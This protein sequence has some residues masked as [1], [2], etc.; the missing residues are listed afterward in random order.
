MIRATT[1]GVLK[2][3][4]MNLNKSYTQ[5]NDAR[6]TVLTQRYFNSYAEDPGAASQAF[7]LRR[8]FVRTNS[9]INTCENATRKFQAAWSAMGSVVD[10]VDNVS[11]V[12]AKAA[13]LMG[14][15]DPT[16]GGRAAL[17]V[18]LVELS[19]SIVQALNVRYGDTFVFA[20]ADGMNVPFTWEDRADGTGKEL[21]YRGIPVDTEVPQV[22]QDSDKTP[23]AYTDANG[24][25]FYVQTS[26]MSTISKTEYDAAKE[27]VDKSANFVKD[28]DTGE[29]E[30]E[31]ID[32]EK[33]YHYAADPDDPTN[34]ENISV[35][36]Y[37]AANELVQNT[38]LL[39]DHSDDPD[40]VPIEYD[41][42]YI[43]KDESTE[44]I[45]KE[46]Y[47]DLQLKLDQLD[48]LCSEK[49]FADIGLGLQE[50]ENGKLIESSAYNVAISGVKFL[51]YG[52]DEDGDP[53]C[54][55]SIIRRLGEILQNCDDNGNFSSESEDSEYTRLLKKFD[56]S[57]DE[58]K[59]EHVDLDSK[60]LFL[61]NHYSQMETNSDTLN[62]QIVEIE[63]VD[64]ADAITAF[65]WAQ[66]CYNAALKVGN[67]IL[68]QSL[69]DYMS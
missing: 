21:C 60:A 46:E 29:F 6:N 30:V 43:V 1:N 27:L 15:N 34:V 67:Q 63:Q 55:V 18:E 11:D 49:L 19:E 31:E 14:E 25:T 48:Y 39:M 26:G 24:E 8:S 42:S 28:A 37:E 7:K 50:D 20:G 23:I 52:V 38:E 22:L 51:G 56:I 3:Y 61:N 44:I 59:R 16:G 33:F 17:G 2:G 5:L 57:A 69:M 47:D 40:G 12:S 54:I 4:R 58:I 41:G 53:K 35:E 10:Y 66:Y 62:E 64:L 45:T 9:Q 36:D 65:S 32:G 68:S 13:S